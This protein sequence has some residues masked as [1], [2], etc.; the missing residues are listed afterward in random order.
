[1][2]LQDEGVEFFP[3]HRQP[4]FVNAHNDALEALAEWGWPGA[5]ALLWLLWL[6]G[7]RLRQ[8]AGQSAFLA[9]AVVAIV[10]VT[11]TN[12][13]WRLALIA[14]PWLLVVA[15]LLD[16][17][18]VGEGSEG[19][20]GRGIKDVASQEQSGGW[21]AR[22]SAWVMAIAALVAAVLLFRVG[23]DRVGAQRLVQAAESVALESERRS[24]M[25][26]QALELG[27][28]L[29]RR[30]EAL[31]P[32]EVSVE[33]TRG[34]LFMVGGRSQAAERSY[35]RAL[36]MENRTEV[37][38]NLARMRLAGG[39]R[40]GALEAARNAQQL[41]TRVARKLPEFPELKDRP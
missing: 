34:G 12:F 13:P 6:V 30:A 9:A 19:E 23:K 27:L 39:D 41:D 29:L 14:F 15:D 8:T 4:Y 18:V 16:P 37:W 11:L 17:K 36:E 32:A 7:R 38:I 21:P 1:M 2:A 22:P 3:G 28:D 35:R 25:P 5:A 33:I 40:E 24:S 26:P 20:Y 10:I 31:D